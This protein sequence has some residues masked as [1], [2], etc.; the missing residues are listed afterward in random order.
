MS[1]NEVTYD[2][3]MTVEHVQSRTDRRLRTEE[4]ILVAAGDLF[5]Q[6]G[7]RKTTVRGIAG[8][9]EVSIGRVMAAGDKDVLLVRCFDRWFAG[10]QTGQYSPPA[11]PNTGTSPEA[12]ENGMTTMPPGTTSAV[13]QHLLGIFLPFLEFFAAHE[14]LSRDYAAALMRVRVKPRV[15]EVLAADLQEKLASNLIAIGINEDYSRA[16]ASVLYDSF[17]GIVF[18][19]SANDLTF[20]EAVASL[21]RTI[22]FHTQVRRLG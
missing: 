12:G 11:R 3:L 9:A 14:D 21:S 18:R 4:K 13:H 7:Y 19:W 17:L 16:S 10:L 6:L 22:A 5:L 15:F 20:D 2:G 1:A 8:R